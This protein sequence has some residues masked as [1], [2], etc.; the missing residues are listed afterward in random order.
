MF[1]MAPK[2]MS[3]PFNFYINF[4]EANQNSLLSE[5]PFQ[6]QIKATRANKTKNENDFDGWS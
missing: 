2:I 3:M 1:E 4:S 5:N 6:Y